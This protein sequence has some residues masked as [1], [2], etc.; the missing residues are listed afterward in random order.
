MERKRNFILRWLILASVEMVVNAQFWGLIFSSQS[1]SSS[2]VMSS[3]NLSTPHAFSSA[4]AVLSPSVTS[5]IVASKS[6]LPSPSTPPVS[7]TTTLRAAPITP[8]VSPAAKPPVCRQRIHKGRSGVITFRQ[9]FNASFP[10][11]TVSRSWQVKEN[12]SG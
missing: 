7:P 4:S 1:P 3:I 8:P 12:K 5:R 10:Q 2:P 11:H 9:F 6:S